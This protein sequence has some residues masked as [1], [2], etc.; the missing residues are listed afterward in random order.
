MNVFV[1][2]SAGYIG[3]AVARVL[4]EAGLAV[5][6]GVR[7]PAA[8]PSWVEAVVTGDLAMGAPDFAGDFAVVH[9]AGLGHRTGV[10]VAEWRAGNLDAA[11]NVARAARA[12]GV[13]RFVLVS[14]AHVHGRVHAGVVRDETAAN[15]MDEYA[16]SKLA[17]EAAVAE[18]FGEGLTIIRPVAVVGPG[19]P[20]N[21]Q[22]VC[23]F[24]AARRPLPLAWIRNRR[25]FIQV[26][27][28]ARLVLAA[29]SAEVAPRVILA[30]HPEPVATPELIRALARGMGV[31]PR[32]WPFP[33]ALLGFFARAAGRGA[34]W[35][36]LAGSF[37]VEPKDALALGWKPRE[38][39][40]D[41]LEKTGAA[42]VV[43]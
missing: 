38:S 22:L 8:L 23:K 28:V 31:T 20:G 7:A 14:T 3:S 30:A 2:G 26:N 37:V 29:I 24:L 36:S 5:R 41:S 13:R 43:A 1:T 6:G 33:P 40:T 25:S 15:P 42:Y 27:D 9:A 39:L 4:A 16:A 35:Q 10:S 12:A 34:M 18:V 32:L 21:L 17:A 11:V 19:C